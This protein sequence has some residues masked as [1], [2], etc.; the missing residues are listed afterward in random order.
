MATTRG[1]MGRARA[2]GRSSP[3]SYANYDPATSSLK[4]H[5]TLPRRVSTGSYVIL[6][7]AGTMQNGTVYEHTTLVR[8]TCGSDCFLLPTPVVSDKNDRGAKT[9][10]SRRRRGKGGSPVL[11]M[12]IGGPS[13]PNHREWL[14]GFPALWTKISDSELRLLETRSFRK[15]LNS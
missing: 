1:S 2:F 13:N 12:V 3:D 10:Y 7:K 4:T 8:H 6:P 15:S 9:D 5:R 11:A 14:M